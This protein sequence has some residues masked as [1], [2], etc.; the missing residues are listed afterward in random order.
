MKRLL[1]CVA[2]ISLA[3]CGTSETTTPETDA[4]T[5]TADVAADVVEDTPLDTVEPDADVTDPDVSGPDADV[6]EP[7]A[8][9][10]ED[11]DAT[12][13]T[14]QCEDGSSYTSDC[15]NCYCNAG[16][17]ECSEDEWCAYEA[18]ISECPASCL[19]A[20]EQPCGS[21]LNYFCTPCH[22]ECSG[23][24]EIDRAVCE[25]PG[26][27]CGELPPDSDPVTFRDW[28]PPPECYV[29]EFVA[30]TASALFA[31]ESTAQAAM[32]C[33]VELGLDFEAGRLVM[34]VFREATDGQVRAVAMRASEAVV[35]MTAPAYCGGPAP[36]NS[37]R[38]VWI[39]ALPETLDV[40][41]CT[42]GECTGPPAP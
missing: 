34:A 16:V 35:Q 28:T 38:L 23:V 33:S 31:S 11:T 6:V 2:A 7:D 40:I 1:R 5:D 17:W 12:G 4:A 32:N 9:V 20:E 8:D 37:I 30:D 27:T 13:D 24:E 3:A 18:C 41:E 22:L 21:S 36:P 15:E 10:E 39:D 14:G 42:Y 25:D 19:P 29:D 26:S